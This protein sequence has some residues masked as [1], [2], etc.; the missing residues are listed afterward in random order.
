[1]LRLALDGFVGFSTAPLRFALTLGFLI[2]VASV[3]YG[4]VT[5][6]PRLAGLPNVPG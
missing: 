5:I 1:M 2:S 4:I 6:A 3:T